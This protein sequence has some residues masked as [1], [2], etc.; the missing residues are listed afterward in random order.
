M[1]RI[2]AIIGLLA[3]ITLVSACAGTLTSDH[4]ARQ[5][6]L[7]EPLSLPAPGSTSEPMPTLALTV[8]AVPGLDTDHI[9][10]I[11]ADSRLNHYANARWADFLPEVLGSVLR[12]SL[13]S[14]GQFDSVKTNTAPDSGDWILELEIQ[15]FYGVQ[16]SSGSTSNI[17][18]EFEGLLMC[19]DQSRHMQLSSS[20]PVHEEKLSVVVKAHQKALDDITGQLLDAISK[21]CQ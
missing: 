10:A 7:L 14:S 1:N 19:K 12:R 4:P 17:V 16:N 2:L 21:N 20:T 15:K 9:Q 18:A 6:Y 8:N 5:Y 13:V 3:S 11:N